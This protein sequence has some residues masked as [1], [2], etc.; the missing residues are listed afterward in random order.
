MSDVASLQS[1]LR[2]GVMELSPPVRGGR[3]GGGRGTESVEAG[4]SET[5][6]HELILGS[7]AATPFVEFGEVNYFVHA[8]LTLNGG[9]VECALHSFIQL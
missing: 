8:L 1:R 3:E 4:A 6:A 5:A 2:G 7:F 9:F